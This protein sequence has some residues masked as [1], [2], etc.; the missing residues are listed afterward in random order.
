MSLI[1]F[2]C[3]GLLNNYCILYA[4]KEIL[5]LHECSQGAVYAAVSSLLPWLAFPSVLTR[6][7]LLLATNF[8][9]DIRGTPPGHWKNTTN[10]LCANSWF[11]LLRHSFENVHE[12]AELCRYSMCSVRVF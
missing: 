4:G 12:A 3:F 11:R 10:R 7:A 8:L 6:E 1:F 9:K 2:L 5:E